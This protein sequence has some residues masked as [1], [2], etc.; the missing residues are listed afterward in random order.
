[1]YI[2]MLPPPYKF[3]S[4]VIRQIDVLYHVNLAVKNI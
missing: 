2:N 4:E 1:M 3:H